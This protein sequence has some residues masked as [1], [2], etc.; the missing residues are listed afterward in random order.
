MIQLINTVPTS[1]TLSFERK[2]RKEGAKKKKTYM[3][4]FEN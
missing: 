4:T 3:Y 2:K 1:E